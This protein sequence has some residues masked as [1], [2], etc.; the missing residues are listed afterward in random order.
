M[1]DDQKKEVIRIT[2]VV[3][4]KQYNVGY[5][6]EL[7]F[8]S[9]TASIIVLVAQLCSKLLFLALVFIRSCCVAIMFFLI[10]IF[11]INIILR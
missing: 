1:N 3:V 5:F 7:I 2:V 9:N 11:N 6:L 10:I 4:G 8:S